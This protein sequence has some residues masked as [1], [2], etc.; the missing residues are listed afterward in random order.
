MRL[1]GKKIV[2]GMTG[3]V[4]CYK[5][6]ELTRALGKAGAHVQVVMTQA[7]TQFITPVTMQALSGNTVFTDQWDARI[8]NNMPHIDLTRDA[9]AIIIAPCSTDFMFKLAHGA[10]DDLLST[11]CIARPRHVPLLIAPAMNVEMW[12]NAATQRNVAQ[13]EEDGIQVLGPAAGDQ[14]CGET[15]M[16]RMLEPEQLLTEIIAAFQPKI[17]AGKHLLITAGPT[18]EP[19]DPVRGITNLSSGKMGYA[20]ALAAW[21]AG[22][23]VTLIS[24]PTALEAPHGVRRIHVQ[25]ALQMHD[26][27]LK[28]LAQHKQDIF[29][30][31]AAVADWRVANASEHK[32]KK[33]QHDDTPQLVFAQN[34]D[35]LATVA[36][37]P[38]A[39]YC[40]G[41]AAESENLLEYGAAKRIKKNIPLLV[42]NIG[43]HT[44]GKDDNELV[45]FDEHGHTALPRADKQTLAIQLLAEIA[46]RLPH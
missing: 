5:V 17:L 16:G 39:P 35:I 32:L 11:L 24:G 6:A 36:A 26:A 34:P 31:V 18:F 21:E 13:I 41:F 12:Q 46:R 23:H 3:G 37:M 14:A 33:T 22:A 8:H 7:A 27:V 44:F 9:D 15:G 43:H 10:C 25:T 2:L 40:V 30:A 38:G 45:L 1:A 20:I 4:A 19:I 29:V 42:G 28:S